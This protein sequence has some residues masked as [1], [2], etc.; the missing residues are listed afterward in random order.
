MDVT[1]LADAI[2]RGEAV[3]VPCDLRD[4]VQVELLSR[5]L[6][7]GPVL[8]ERPRPVCDVAV[9]QPVSRHDDCRPGYRLSQAARDSI[10]RKQLAAWAARKARQGMCLET[11]VSARP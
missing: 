6:G 1:G 5:A 7:W 3:A 2:E 11:A 4:S 10:S 8:N 9:I